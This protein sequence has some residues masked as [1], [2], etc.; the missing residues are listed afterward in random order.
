[1]DDTPDLKQRKE[2]ARSTIERDYRE[3]RSATRMWSAIYNSQ[4]Q[5]DLIGSCHDKADGYPKASCEPAS[6]P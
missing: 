4:Y 1:M 2:K 5:E 6:D 3:F